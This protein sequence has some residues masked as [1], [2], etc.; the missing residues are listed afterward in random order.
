MYGNSLTLVGNLTREPD[1]RYTPSGQAVVS[2]GLAINNNWTDR[3]TGEKHEEAHFYEVQ[4]WRTL[5]ENAAESL[6]QGDRVIV[7][8]QL[9]FEQWQNDA[10][11]NRSKHVVEADSIGP[12]L[13][14]ATCTVTKTERQSEVQS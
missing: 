12:D 3:T 10:G 2:F 1:L 13:R 8:G 4:A 6:H 9:K 11:E 14:W 7:S 5:A